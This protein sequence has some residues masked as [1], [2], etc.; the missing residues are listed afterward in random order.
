VVSQSNKSIMK[1]AFI[2]LETNS[3]ENK[4]TT[5]LAVLTDIKKALYFYCQPPFDTT[6]ITSSLATKKYM[7]CSTLLVPQYTR[8][9]HIFFIRIYQRNDFQKKM[10]L[11]FTWLFDNWSSIIFRIGDSC[12]KFSNQNISNAFQLLNQQN[13]VRIRANKRTYFW[14]INQLHSTFIIIFDLNTHTVFPVN[15]FKYKALQLDYSLPPLLK[16]I[17]YF[18][19][20]YYLKNQFHVQHHHPH[21]Q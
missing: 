14:E 5:L 9:N 3:I 4:V 20:F 19:N 21:F 17:E 16:Y 2:L 13:L 11:L 15:R 8:E 1:K 6:E 18:S 12:L 7:S 10:M